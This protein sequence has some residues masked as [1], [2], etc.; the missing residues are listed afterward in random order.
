MKKYALISFF[1]VLYI[2]GKAQGT[3]QLL[4]H[5]PKVQTAEAMAVQRYTN[6]PMDYSTGLPN[7]TI[8]LYE[9]K[10]GDITLPITLSYH[11]SGL[12]PNEAPGRIATG[13]T[14]NAE[15]SISKQVRG[16][17]D[18]S[19]YGLANYDPGLYKD[20]NGAN[21]Y[22]KQIADG[23]IDA[24]SDVYFYRLADK[25][26]AFV[27]ANG[28]NNKQFIPQPYSEIKITGSPNNVTI[29]EENGITY[30]F[31]GADS[32][33][34]RYSSSRLPVSLL[35]KEITSK[36]TKAKIS[37]VYNHSGL[38]N[39]DY[40][41]YFSDDVVVVGGLR[42]SRTN[43]PTITKTINGLSRT[44][45]YPSQGYLYEIY[46]EAG[47][48]YTGTGKTTAMMDLQPLREIKFDNGSVIFEGDNRSWIDIWV[49]DKSN[50]IIKEI[51]LYC[52]PYNPWGNT[53]MQHRKL[54]SVRIRVP[55]GDTQRY[56]FGYHDPSHTPERDTRSTDYWG[57][58]NGVYDAD[59]LSTVPSFTTVVTN[60]N[61]VQYTYEHTGMSRT[62][63]AW[64]TQTGVLNRITDPNGAETIFE[65]EGNRTGIQY[66]GFSLNYGQTINPPPGFWI[67]YFDYYS[68]QL[69]IDVPVGGLRIR[70]IIEKDPVTEKETYREF[71]YGCL[72]R[73]W[74]DY[75]IDT[76]GVPKRMVGPNAFVTMQSYIQEGQYGSGSYGY[77]TRTWHSNPVVDITYNGGTPILYSRVTERKWGGGNDNIWTEHY[78]TTPKH[79]TFQGEITY[80]NKCN[81]YDYDCI[82]STIKIKIDEGR[83]FSMPF[84]F[85]HFSDEEYGKL[86][87][88]TDYIED[89]GVKRPVRKEE[90][91]NKFLR[92]RWSMPMWSDY[93]YRIQ[94][95]IPAEGQS[96]SGA[97]DNEVYRTPYPKWEEEG[98]VTYNVVEKE[99]ITEYFPAG[100]FVSLSKDFM[101]TDTETTTE[102]AIR[103][104]VRRITSHLNGEKK[105]EEYFTYSDLVDAHGYTLT[106]YPENLYPQELTSNHPTGIL[107]EHKVIV[108]TDTTYTRQKMERVSDTFYKISAI[109]TKST[110]GNNFDEVLSIKHNAYGN[111]V[112][113][114]GMDGT[115]TAYIWSC[116]FQ[117]LVAKVENATYDNVCAALLQSGMDISSLNHQQTLSAG[118]VAV[119]NYLKIRLPDAHVYTYT[120]K[121]L[122]GMTSATDPSGKTTYYEYDT[123]NRLKRT[124]FKEKNASG[125]EVERNIESYEYNFKK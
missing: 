47:I 59:N 22:N 57:F 121:P 80:S 81:S 113:T 21:F 107:A 19:P 99:T 95:F 46:E 48:S 89:G 110:P 18:S 63:N 84:S 35:C 53:D 7:I 124:Y 66:S 23:K 68:P 74:G 51:T 114:T 29:E 39:F 10:V 65:Y 117:Y 40:N 83:D 9:I 70:R 58:F 34:D 94:T 91:K 106:H 38:V 42:Q 102:S 88:K 12:K 118:T 93:V 109:K 90:Y 79:D 20:V 32:Y 122:V 25:G 86:Y 52:S 103:P 69:N 67:L 31:G 112:E 37:F 98:R 92:Y 55:G 76:W 100:D 75:I 49:K 82:F 111:I 33:I 96:G 101:Y 30:K 2:L 64:A 125:V 61:N 78:Y 3:I 17:D 77:S 108:G 72:T 44:Y 116:Y 26:G 43:T 6:Y 62:P 15:P 28:G 120:Y 24:M 56:T 54:D 41:S 14:L 27:M 105:K 115:P 13:W 45:E 16:I 104:R 71:S 5:L 87:K 119:L 73:D 123:S 11:S 4:N 8:P 97:T 50:N 85:R 1:L 60:R 36:M